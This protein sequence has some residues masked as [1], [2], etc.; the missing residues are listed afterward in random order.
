MY[1]FNNDCTLDD[2]GRG[3][4]Y[5]YNG[6]P[7]VKETATTSISSD[8]YF[9]KLRLIGAS[10]IVQ[11]INFTGGVWRAACEYDSELNPTILSEKSF[12]NRT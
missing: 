11:P 1:I 12:T 2:W 10:I 9:Q 7:A 8:F 5:L 3:T 6:R 4:P